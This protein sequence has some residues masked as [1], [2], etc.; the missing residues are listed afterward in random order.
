MAPHRTAAEAKLKKRRDTPITPNAPPII[1][2]NP[3]LRQRPPVH[4]KLDHI[5][6]NT[7]RK[8]ENT[9]PIS[10]NVSGSC[11]TK[12]RLQSSGVMAALPLWVGFTRP[13]H[14]FTGNGERSHSVRPRQSLV[15]D[16]RCWFNEQQVDRIS[17]AGK[18]ER[19][20][21]RNAI[22][23]QGNIVAVYRHCHLC[24]HECRSRP[25][26]RNSKPADLGTGSQAADRE[27]D[28]FMTVPRSR[29]G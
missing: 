7:F 19:P 25:A 10:N 28:D 15:S 9:N 24:L 16:G 22:E 14:P 11:D 20:V 17:R 21:F 4:G 13:M 6:G 27:I 23:P 26:Q 1:G 12:I 2:S 5:G 18:S 29:P 8:P 3:T